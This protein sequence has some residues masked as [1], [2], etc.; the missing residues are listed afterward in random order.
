MGLGGVGADRRGVLSEAGG[1]THCRLDDDVVPAVLF[2]Q[3]MERDRCTTSDERR[4]HHRQATT[5]EVDEIT[6]VRVPSQQRCRI[7]HDRLLGVEMIQPSDERRG[8]T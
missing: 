2:E 1:A 3:V 6:L 7:V 4:R 5:A 8:A